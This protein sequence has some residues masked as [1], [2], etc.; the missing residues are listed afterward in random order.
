MFLHIFH[1]RPSKYRVLVKCCTKE[2]Y[3]HTDFEKLEGTLVLS[4]AIRLTGVQYLTG[5]SRIW[6]FVWYKN[7]SNTRQCMC[8]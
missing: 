6:L 4:V 8:Q 2:I 5:V 3:V 7:D 1:T